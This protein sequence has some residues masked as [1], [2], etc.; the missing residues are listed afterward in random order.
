MNRFVA[1]LARQAFSLCAFTGC[2]CIFPAG[3]DDIPPPITPPGTLMGR[4]GTVHYIDPNSGE[5]PV[6]SGFSRHPAT[7]ARVTAPAPA[8]SEKDSIRDASESAIVPVPSEATV[9][10]S[11][12]AP[13]EAV[14]APPPVSVPRSAPMVPRRPRLFHVLRKPAP[15]EPNIGSAI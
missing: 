6:E 14:S 15:T 4:Q 2:F 3:A 7:P 12:P 1:R 11:V 10:P 8:F 9:P 13:P 5:T